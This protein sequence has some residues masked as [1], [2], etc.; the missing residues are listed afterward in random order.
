[1]AKRLEK[2]IINIKR[3]ESGSARLGASKQASARER[4]RECGRVSPTHMHTHQPPHLKQHQLRAVGPAGAPLRVEHVTLPGPV[5]PPHPAVPP[6]DPQPCE[7]ERKGE[8]RERE[9][10]RPVAT[11][12]AHVLRVQAHEL[13]VQGAPTR[14]AP[15]CLPL[16][17]CAASLESLR[18]CARARCAGCVRASRASHRHAF[19]LSLSLCHSLPP[20]LSLPLARPTVHAPDGRHPS[21]A[22]LAGQCPP[23]GRL[24]RLGPHRVELYPPRRARRQQPPPPARTPPH[25]PRTRARRW[26]GSRGRR[27]SRGSGGQGTG[28]GRAGARGTREAT[29]RSWR[30]PSERPSWTGGTG[31][32][33]GVGGWGRRARVSWG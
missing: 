12:Q 4:A 31:W 6:L 27:E 29:E 5:H 17:S 1:M 11:W 33:D 10:V 16:L 22:E 19:S 26:P 15:P 25:A 32:G 2:A 24:G 9:R 14:P 21:Q 13:R 8:A 7:R 20:S 28:G 3:R 18:A 23:P 30:V